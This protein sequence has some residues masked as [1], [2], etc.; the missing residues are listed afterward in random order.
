MPDITITMVLR[1][2]TNDGQL[3][4]DHLY[5]DTSQLIWEAEPKIFEYG[6]RAAP[7]LSCFLLFFLDSFSCPA[8][9]QAWKDFLA[10]EKLTEE[11]LLKNYQIIPK[12]SPGPS[13]HKGL[14]AGGGEAGA[15]QALTLLENYFLCRLASPSMATTKL[16]ASLCLC[17]SSCS[18][19]TAFLF[20]RQVSLH[21]ETTYQLEEHFSE[22]GLPG[23][24]LTADVCPSLGPLALASPAKPLTLKLKVRDG[25]VAVEFHGRNF[26]LRA[27]LTDCQLNVSAALNAFTCRVFRFVFDQPYFFFQAAATSTPRTT[28]W[29]KVTDPTRLFFSILCFSLAIL[30]FL[31]FSS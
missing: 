12:V 3:V 18:F 4:H 29:K 24:V 23:F 5:G 21:N 20:S 19:L 22:T 25:L 31:F 2:Y 14:Y 27:N 6:H 8:L 13:Y 15:L 28:W 1:G 30:C 11:N 7:W 9:S 26:P 17:F 10:E 16:Q